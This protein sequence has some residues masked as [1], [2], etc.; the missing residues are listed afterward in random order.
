MHNFQLVYVDANFTAEI[1]HLC[2]E[3]HSSLWKSNQLAM[4][5]TL[6]KLIWWNYLQKL[7]LARQICLVVQANSCRI[8]LLLS[9]ALGDAV[10]E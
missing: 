3:F 9:L 5:F 10:E 2:Y 6:V 1:S 7:S 8:I 4:T